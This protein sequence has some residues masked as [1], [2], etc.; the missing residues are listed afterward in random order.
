MKTFKKPQ[1]ISKLELADV[2][3]AGVERALQVR[4][5]SEQE[6]SEVSGGALAL[7]KEIIAGGIRAA[8]LDSL[9]SKMSTALTGMDSGMLTQDFTTLG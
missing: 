9:A 6:V 5:L 3:A 4:E 2:T 8:Y 1:R 7:P